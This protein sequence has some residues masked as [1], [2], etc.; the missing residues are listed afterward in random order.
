MLSNKEWSKAIVWIVNLHI[1]DKYDFEEVLN[2]IYCFFFLIIL[3]KITSNL[4]NEN[5]LSLLKLFVGESNGRKKRLINYFDRLIGYKLGIYTEN[6]SAIEKIIVE[7]KRLEKFTIRFLRENHFAE[8]LIPN[9][10]TL[11]CRESLLFHHYQW[12]KNEITFVNFEENAIVKKKKKF[13]F[14]FN[15]N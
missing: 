10:M 13:L 3:I 9:I 14:L 1:C 2:E 15:L 5:L 7:G 4:F 12:R 8:I 6:L 11:R